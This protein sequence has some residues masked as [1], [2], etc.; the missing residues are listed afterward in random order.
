MEKLFNDIDLELLVKRKNS[1]KEDFRG[2]FY[3]DTTAIIHSSPF[4]RLKHKTQVFFAPSND[5]ICTRMEHVLHV[6]SIASTICRPLG[7]DT[8][9]AWA[10]G[11]GHDLGHTPFGHVGEVIMDKISQAKGF[12]CFEHEV[13]SLRVVD[14][15]SDNGKGLNLTYEVRDGIVCHTCGKEADTLEGRIVKLADKIAYLN[16]DI[17]DAVRAGVMRESDIPLDVRE[18]LG[19]SKSKRIDTLV[20][21]AIANSTQDITLSLEVAEAF[22]ELNRF[23]F[24]SV[25][26]N[27]VCKGEESKAEALIKSLYGYY[28]QHPNE[29][30][31]SFWQTVI[32]E[33]AERAACDYVTGMSDSYVLSVYHQIFIPKA[34]IEKGLY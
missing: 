2:A 14:K 3:R 16:H 21:S 17:D 8:E 5:H 26:T 23:M 12:G 13:N 28:A 15:L 30:P 20:R 25:Y 34:W 29:L 27:P 19:D 10:I 22:A 4:R 9:L 33:G 7:L 18:T 11:M 24:K 6:S 32:S 1:R 31:S